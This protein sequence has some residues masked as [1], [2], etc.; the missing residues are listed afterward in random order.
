M[1]HHAHCIQYCTMFI[2]SIHAYNYQLESLGLFWLLADYS[3]LKT[4]SLESVS[5]KFALNPTDM[6]EV[7]LYWWWPI[8]T[9]INNHNDH[10]DLIDW[11]DFHI[12]VF[13]NMSISHLWQEFLRFICFMCCL[14]CGGAVK[15]N[16]EFLYSSWA[17]VP[18]MLDFLLNQVCNLVI[19]LVRIFSATIIRFKFN[20]SSI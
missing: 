8:T 15:Q 7:E 19:W 3:D 18:L 11:K 9:I 16:L 20:Y 17:M 10:N 6:T 4:V 12:F 13:V 14:K 1:S 2:P 5:F